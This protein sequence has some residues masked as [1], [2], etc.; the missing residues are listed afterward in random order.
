MSHVE[1]WLL[2]SPPLSTPVTEASRVLRRPPHPQPAKGPTAPAPTYRLSPHLLACLTKDQRGSATAPPPRSLAP[3]PRSP[4]AGLLAPVHSSLSYD[5][6]GLLPWASSHPPSSTPL[7]S[8]VSEPHR[9]QAPAAKVPAAPGRQGADGCPQPTMHQARGFLPSP[10]CPPGHWG[11]GGRHVER[12]QQ[13][14]PSCRLGCGCG[15]PRGAHCGLGDSPSPWLSPK[16]R[17][18]SSFFSFPK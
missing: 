9:S 6:L 13:L 12:G 7:S 4:E 1:F 10:P 15:A 18:T 5:P 17:D 14:I 16:G 2:P 3:P 11:G 8:G